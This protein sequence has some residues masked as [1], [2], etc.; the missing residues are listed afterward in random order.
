VSVTREERCS[1]ANISRAVTP[2]VK[3]A[4]TILDAARLSSISRSQIYAEIQSG[5]LS[6]IKIGGRTLILH[7]SLVAWLR[8]RPRKRSKLESS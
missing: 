3:M 5:R 1:G 4:Y 2:G 7:D 8:S 6:A